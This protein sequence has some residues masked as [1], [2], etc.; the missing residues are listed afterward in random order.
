[1]RF[2]FTFLL[3]S[4]SIQNIQAQDI[5]GQIIDKQT[6]EAIPY[7][8]IQ[9]NKTKGTISNEEGFFNLDIENTASKT[10]TISCMGYLPKVVTLEKLKANNNIITLEMAINTLKEVAIDN[11]IPNADSILS[12]VNLKFKDNY[13]YENKNHKFFYRESN[14]ANFKEVDFEVEKAKH[15]RKKTIE[16]L[17][18]DIKAFTQN[19]KSSDVK[20]YVDLLGNLYINESDKTKLTVSK[21]TNL[22]DK[23]KNFNS[24]SIE[25]KVQ[26]AML[27]VLDTSKTFK[28]KTGII[29]IEDSMSLK[30]SQNKE[31]KANEYNN[32]KLKD[33]LLDIIQKT[34]FHDDS[35]IRNIIDTDLYNY[36][37]ED[38]S[39]YNNELVYI[40]NFKPRRSKSKFSGKLYITEED[41]AILRLDYSFA[42]GKRGTKVNLKFLL[43]IKYVE[44][45]NAGTILFKKN[46]NGTYVPSYIKKVDNKYFYLSRSFKLIEN[47]DKKLKTK[48]DLTMELDN[49]MKREILFINTEDINN[50]DYDTIQEKEKVPYINIEK[51]NPD[52]WKNEKIIEPLLEMKKFGTVE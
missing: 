3:I 5:N 52:L 21:V 22:I 7:A 14:A 46:D 15:L 13:N 16:D 29:K 48:F 25:E 37:F 43:G 36:E 28:L 30:D 17:N 2:L 40:I 50:N 44:N 19:V 27:K 32:I 8:S 24:E 1:M 42:K 39:F 18:K 6:K 38:F 12:M 23:N 47:S 4:I 34:K 51:Y 41:Y 49:L 20:H 10:L 26:I 9:V 45:V 35:F 11:S 33:D 31:V